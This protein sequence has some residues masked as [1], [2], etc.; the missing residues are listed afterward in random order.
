MDLFE[1][2]HGFTRA[3][4]VQREGFYPYFMPISGSDGTEVRI[5]HRSAIM[6][7]S[8]NYLGLTHHPHVIESAR[9]ALEKFGS[10]CTGSRFLNGTLDL[11]IELEERVGVAA[12][13]AQDVEVAIVLRETDRD[14]R[15]PKNGKR[16][17]P[18]EAVDGPPVVVSRVAVVQLEHD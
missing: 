5:G 2:C 14:Q 9:K 12:L 17:I 16:R 4:E 3:R 1:K 15:Q 10:S 11:H 13:I 7:G 6:V 8:N 18:L